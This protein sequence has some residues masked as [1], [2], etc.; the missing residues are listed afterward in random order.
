MGCHGAACAVVQYQVRWHGFGPDRDTLHAAEDECFATD[1]GRKALQE[2]SAASPAI[3]PRGARLAARSHGPLYCPES[4][5][6]AKRLGAVQVH[7]C[8]RCG[9][10]PVCGP[11][12]RPGDQL[13]HE[14]LSR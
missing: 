8:T 12:R 10:L 5:C 2:Y 1:S 11:I 4:D 9:L 13:K 7:R 14:C 6:D 3:G